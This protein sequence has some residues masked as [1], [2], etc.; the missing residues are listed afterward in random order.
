MTDSTDPA[1]AFADFWEPAPVEDSGPVLDPSTFWAPPTPTPPRDGGIT[2][3]TPSAPRR[4]SPKHTV[5]PVSH[6]GWDPSCTDPE[7]P[8]I[9][10]VKPSTG[11]QLVIAGLNA[12]ADAGTLGPQ[13]RFP[14]GTTFRHKRNRWTSA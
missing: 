8:L 4:K 11:E 2:E 12:A 10:R 6:W 14:V 1:S 13:S 9:S 7:E 5:N 3:D